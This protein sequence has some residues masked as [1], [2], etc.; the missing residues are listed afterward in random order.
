MTLLALAPVVALPW[1]HGFFT[2]S[3]VSES[4]SHE[5]VAELGEWRPADEGCVAGSFGGMSV[6]AELDGNPGEER[7]LASYTQGLVVL[8]SERHMIA[9]APGF[10]CEG[11]ADEL[12]AIATGDAAIGAPVVVL[13]ATSGGRNLSMTWMTIYRVSNGGELQPVFI[14][15]VERHDGSTTRTG[16]VT[17]VPGGLVH[18][19]P[20]GSL[21]LWVYDAALGRYVQELSTRPFV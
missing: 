9:H 21:S 14:G 20:A 15:E 11:S 16:T 8:D 7:V 3:G 4:S 5:V 17:V 6:T 10:D 12:V 18:R 13:A 19:D 2:P 1:L